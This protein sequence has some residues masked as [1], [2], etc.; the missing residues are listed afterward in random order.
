MMPANYRVMTAVVDYEARAMIL[1]SIDWR[2]IEQALCI[3][4][5]KPERL[6]NKASVNRLLKLIKDMKEKEL[7]EEKIFNKRR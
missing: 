4:K 2:N 6:K 3:A 1:P 5:E 7:E